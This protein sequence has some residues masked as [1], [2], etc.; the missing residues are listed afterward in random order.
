MTI[1]VMCDV[2]GDTVTIFANSV[3][4]QLSLADAQLLLNHLEYSIIEMIHDKIAKN[5]T[6][7]ITEAYRE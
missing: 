2:A 3:K 1:G 7:L 6:D 4:V 5:K